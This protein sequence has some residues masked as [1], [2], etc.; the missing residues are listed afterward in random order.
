MTE[1][2]SKAAHAEAEINEWQAQWTAAIQPL[3][4][5][6]ASTPAAVNEVVAQTAELFTDSRNRP[7]T[8]SESMA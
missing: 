7:A 1:A 6:G 5:P 3:G 2:E 8:R 4:L